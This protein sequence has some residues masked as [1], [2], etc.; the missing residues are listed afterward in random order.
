MPNTR[1]RQVFNISVWLWFSGIFY[2]WCFCG[3]G[4]QEK[5]FPPL[6]GV[7]WGTAKNALAF[8]VNAGYYASIVSNSIFHWFR[9]WKYDWWSGFGLF[10]WLLDSWNQVIVRLSNEFSIMNFIRKFPPSPEIYAPGTPEGSPTPEGNR[11]P[12]SSV[13]TVEIVTDGVTHFDNRSVL[14]EVW[15]NYYNYYNRISIQTG[16][17]NG[18]DDVISRKRLTCLESRLGTL[19]GGAV[20]ALRRIRQRRILTK[21]TPI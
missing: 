21:N 11:S 6:F 9:R 19:C 15:I 3:L 17:R 8:W 4:R 12:A 16:D 7:F 20:R 5:N 2:N 1:W 10:E 13:E 14:R 18:I